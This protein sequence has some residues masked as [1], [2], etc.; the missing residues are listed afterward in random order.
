M[1]D[2]GNYM[3]ADTGRG[4]KAEET[5]KYAAIG[6]GVAVLARLLVTVLKGFVRGEMPAY[7]EQ[8]GG[9]THGPDHPP[10]TPGHPVR[11]AAADSLE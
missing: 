10:R 3:S 9:Q 4:H 5:L 6:Y 1:P 11:A 2:L 7:Q 8:T